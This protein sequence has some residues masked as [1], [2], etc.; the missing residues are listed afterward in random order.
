MAT[1]VAWTEARFRAFIVS[2]LRKA[3]S[4]WPVK[5]QVMKEACVGRSINAST[6]K[7]ALHYKCASCCGTFPAKAVAV[8]HIQPVVA[9]KDGF[10]NWDTFI[11]RLFCNKEGLQVLCKVCHDAKTAMERKERK[12]VHARNGLGNSG[13]DGGA[14]HEGGL[15]EHPRRPEEGLPTP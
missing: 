5:Y 8:D 6:G 7:M 10:V 9:T 15:Q 11:A 14:G 12:D 3:S 13:K 1:D 4:R 2:A